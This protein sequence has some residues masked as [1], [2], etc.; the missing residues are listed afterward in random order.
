MWDLNGYTATFTASQCKLTGLG[1]PEE[2]MPADEFSL[3]STPMTAMTY[4]SSLETRSTPGRPTRQSSASSAHLAR[5][6]GLAGAVSSS[7]SRTNPN[8]TSSA[9]TST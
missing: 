5:P 7:R 9:P 8:P 2:P 3:V 6:S 4:R 1:K